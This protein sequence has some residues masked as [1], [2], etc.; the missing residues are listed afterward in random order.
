MS[1]IM[2]G[3]PI[4][5]TGQVVE[6]IIF[7]PG[8]NKNTRK[9]LHDWMGLGIHW[10][11]GERGAEAVGKVLADR[12]LS[13]HF[14]CEP[15]GQLV[16]TADLSTRCA[17]IGSPGNDR[18]LGVETSCRGFAT[19]EDWEAATKI[20]PSLRAREDIDWETPRDTYVDKIDGNS[21]RFA[22]FNKAQLISLIWLAETLAGVCHFPRAIPYREISRAEVDA[23]NWPVPNVADFLVEI[24]GKLY[25]P[26]FSRDPS[27][28]GRA[29]T[30]KGVLGHFHVHK[31]KMD[32][33]TQIMYALWAEGWNPAKKALRGATTL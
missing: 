10:T 29:L 17:H 1:M 6:N 30:W 5:D 13:I 9:Q 14:I 19:K 16:Q 22:G 2:N 25:M 23:T 15:S 7:K 8:T 11:G 31:N 27:K 28:K 26:D 3:K 20:D 12:E 21:A 24:G 32:P 4:E 18:F 33:G